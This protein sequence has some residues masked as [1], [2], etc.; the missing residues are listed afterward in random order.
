MQSREIESART[1]IIP[2]W[3]GSEM[4]ELFATGSKFF[5]EMGG[6]P[7]PPPRT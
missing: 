6:Y 1:A 3:L 4:S 7:L 5:V 2:D